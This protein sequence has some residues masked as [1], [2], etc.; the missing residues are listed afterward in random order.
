ME[1][2]GVFGLD[3]DIGEIRAGEVQL[4]DVEVQLWAG[5]GV[6][7]GECARECGPAGGVQHRRAPAD[8]Q[9]VAGG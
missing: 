9:A 4:A 7:A 8:D 5:S 6:A 3:L 1:A 2:G